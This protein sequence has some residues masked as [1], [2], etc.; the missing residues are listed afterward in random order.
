M[1][2]PEHLEMAIMGA[3][4]YLTI[5]RGDSAATAETIFASCD[6]ELIQIVGRAMARRLGVQT[7][8]RLRE[9]THKRRNLDAHPTP[10]D[11]EQSD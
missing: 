3:R 6:P 5:A 8:D 11:G 9:V 4:L 2:A 7:P 1:P 10:S